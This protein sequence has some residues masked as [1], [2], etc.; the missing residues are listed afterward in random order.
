MTT[1][2]PQANPLLCM[3][4]VTSLGIQCLA[5]A[6]DSHAQMLVAAQDVQEPRPQEPEGDGRER[7]R[8]ADKP[9]SYSLSVTVLGKGA[10]SQPPVK[11]ATVTLF[12]GDHKASSQTGNN[13]KV[14]FKFNTAAKRATVRVVAGHW[15]PD[16]QQVDL[17]DPDKE[18]KVLLKPSD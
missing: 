17:D 5:P 15:Q 14:T 6:R 18:H 13:G 1:K 12:A 10:S 7:T 11:G 3:I 2:N 9:K 16:Q 4:L 8:P